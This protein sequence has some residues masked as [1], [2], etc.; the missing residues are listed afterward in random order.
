VAGGG[1][2]T[3]SAVA[4]AFVGTDA[5]LGLVPLGT[6]NSTAHTLGI[7]PSIRRAVDAIAWGEVAD[8]DL[9]KIGDDYFMNVVSVGLTAET[10]QNTPDWLKKLLGK[11]AYLITGATVF[12][13]HRPFLCCLQID[14]RRV[15][16]KARQV[17]IANGRYFGE[18]VLSPEA[19]IR[20]SLLTVHAV[21][22]MDFWYLVWRLLR[23]LILRKPG[24]P[25]LLHFS[26]S[27]V[28]IDA[29]PPQRIDIDGESTIRTPARVSV[30]PRAL[31]VMLPAAN[32]R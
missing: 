28:S 16:A 11:F 30:I 29:D 1:D 26:V 25:G 13:R 32:G 18:T 15:T 20:D 21:E 6:G 2:G 17:V 10:A 31:K 8:I 12:I 19:S 4:D 27:E 7:P 3:F 14:G 23:F 22:E 9:G 24:L 5:V